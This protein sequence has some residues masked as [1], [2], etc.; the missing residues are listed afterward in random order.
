MACSILEEK[1]HKRDGV[2]LTIAEVVVSLDL[3]TDRSWILA[4][5]SEMGKT[6]KGLGS[7]FL[8]DCTRG[9]K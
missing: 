2:P 8:L 5:G 9:F 7:E 6:N 3:F 4:F 1:G